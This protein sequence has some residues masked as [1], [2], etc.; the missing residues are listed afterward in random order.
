M[1]EKT[2]IHRVTISKIE[3][4]QQSSLL[5]FIQILRGLEEL[6]KL[7]NIVSEESLSPLQ[8]AKLE[9]KKRQRAS[10]KTNDKITNIKQEW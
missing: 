3:N 7:D 6:E 1:P 8:L 10:R 5:S 2:G 4:G 9:G